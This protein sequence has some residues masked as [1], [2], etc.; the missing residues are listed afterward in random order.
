MGQGFGDRGLRKH[1]AH[2]RP[3]R[4]HDPG[5]L[6]GAALRIPVGT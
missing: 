1:H 3:A 6:E 5:F 2:R 4:G